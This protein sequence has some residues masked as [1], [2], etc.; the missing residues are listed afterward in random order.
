MTDQRAVLRYG[1]GVDAAALP[2]PLGTT[3]TD[4]TPEAALVPAD[5]QAAP[6][7]QATV[8]YT[9]SIQKTSASVWRTFFNDTAWAPP[10]AGASALFAGF[11]RNASDGL[12]MSADGASQLAVWDAETVVDVILDNLD[13]GD[14]PFHLHGHKF[15]L[16]AR[17]TGRLPWSGASAWNAMNPLRRDTLLVPAYTWAV[18]RVRLDHAGYWAL[19]CHIA[20]H[21]A[22]G[23]LTQLVAMPGA[24]LLAPAALPPRMAQMCA[25]RGS[26]DGEE[27]A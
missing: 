2:A 12:M 4:K 15:W 21:M 6:P 22:A 11:A 20:W 17:G 14:H 26:A 19:H 18:L 27:T 7:A 9:F 3:P 10:R 23:G 25:D 13:D 16:M 5:V 24:D 1:S 8:L